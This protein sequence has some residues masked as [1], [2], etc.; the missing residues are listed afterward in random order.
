MRFGKI[1]IGLCALMCFASLSA[2][3]KDRSEAPPLDESLAGGSSVTYSST[4][5]SASGGAGASN[6]SAS[7]P[8]ESTTS[9]VHNHKVKETV[10]PTCVEDGWSE[11]V[12][13]C[14]DKY[15]VELAA[16]GHN[17]SKTNV[18]ADCENNGYT[19]YTCSNC[20]DSYDD[21]A[22]DQG[23]LGHSWG[24]WS[25]TREATDSA[26]GEKQSV[27]SR[28]G[29]TR[30]EAIPKTGG[31]S[32]SNSFVSEVV[33]LVNIERAN[34]G[35][36]ALK[37]TEVLDEYA[38]TR[39]NEIV[40]NFA[41]ERPDGSSPLNYVLGL[42]GVRTCGENIA[43]GYSTPE[44]VVDAWMNSPGHRANILKEDF[45]MIGVG[46]CKSGSKYYWTQIFAG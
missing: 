45:T 27:C 5:I 42:S 24:G 36:A 28:C 46:Y 17:Y 11:F 1:S 25:V 6:E 4:D 43:N 9:H 40:G 21:T 29:K 23:A 2:G 14:G 8:A 31:A 10:E 3:C 39:S 18:D 30:S 38:Q 22:D 20:G 44:A 32:S 26:D 33:R 13:E 15:S 7:K 34:Y 16:T 19:R 12:C 41:H 37:E 35:L